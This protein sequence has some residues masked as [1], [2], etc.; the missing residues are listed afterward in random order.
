VGGKWTSFRAFAEQ[1]TDKTLALLGK[2]RKA[3]TK[4]LAIGGGKDYPR[5]GLAEIEFIKQV[6][7]DTG[8]GEFRPKKLF[9]RY[10]TRALEIA[11]YIRSAHDEPLKSM[12]DWSR[13]EVEFLVEREKAVHVDDLLLRRSTLAWLGQVTR[14]LVEELAEIMSGRLG[15][16]AAQTQAEVRRTLDL[17]KD[18]HG[19]DLR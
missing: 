4:A 19:V 16:S 8:L 5:V 6:A 13:R 7:E 1:V 3:D 12:P 15:W 18:H 11:R 14:P 9:A 10:G 17:L 2:P